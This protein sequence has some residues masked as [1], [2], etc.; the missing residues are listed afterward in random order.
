MSGFNKPNQNS[1]NLRIRQM[2]GSSIAP[3]VI[4]NNVTATLQADCNIYKMPENQIPNVTNYMY[5]EK[6]VLQLNTSLIRVT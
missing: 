1:L 2:N 5:D 4:K 6:T 3:N